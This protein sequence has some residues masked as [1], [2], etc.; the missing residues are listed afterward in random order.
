VRHDRAGLADCTEKQVMATTA[1][2][3]DLAYGEL[4]PFF[5]GDA[6]KCQKAID[7]QAT[8][9][10]VGAA[11]AIGACVDKVNDGE[12]AGSA[13]ALCMGAST[14]AGVEAPGDKKT[15]SKLTALASAAQKALASACP[16]TTATA[17]QS[18][19]SDPAT[20]ATSVQCPGWRQ[21]IANTVAA[22]GD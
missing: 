18:C 1:A 13:Q 16:G 21:V 10:L 19:R 9:Y 7:A 12:L 3:L 22:Y 14:A 8:K 2:V 20:L 11:I 6:R 4:Q 17:L 5:D 15:S